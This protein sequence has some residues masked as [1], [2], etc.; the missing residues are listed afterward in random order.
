M[1]AN[2]A[3]AGGGVAIV[4]GLVALCKP[5]VGDKRFWPVL[6][7]AFGLVLNIG[8]AYFRA[9]D[10][11]TAVILGVMSGLSA[12]GLYSGVKNSSETPQ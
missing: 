7:L 10:M 1:D 2:V 5:F 8:L 12:S 3:I 11:T 6:G 4:I 9:T